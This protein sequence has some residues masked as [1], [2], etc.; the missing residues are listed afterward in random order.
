MKKN[1][2]NKN[3]LKYN[4]YYLI[5]N[6]IFEK[7]KYKNILIDQIK[8]KI[9]N[10][11]IYNFIIFKKFDWNIITTTIINKNFLYKKKLIIINYV[12]YI[13]NFFH[14][15]NKHIFSHIKNKKIYI[16][17]N[18]EC[19]NLVNKKFKKKK[20]KI[21]N[22]FKNYKYNKN[23]NILEIKYYKNKYIKKLLKYIK[24]KK[25]KDISKIFYKIKYKN[26]NKLL[27]LNILFN[28]FIKN[29]NKFK[30]FK[31]I[32]DILNMFYKYDKNIKTFNNLKLNNLELLCLLITK[33]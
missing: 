5:G 13:Q 30:N 15:C 12:E 29:I 1:F 22:F 10:I 9:I 21:L 18:F 2:N 6:N 17:F 8:K 28:W 25:L 27:L 16:I 33:I 32:I 26:I 14:L 31:K 3:I 19:T 23:F 11:N 20:Y 24:K 7:Q 4:Y